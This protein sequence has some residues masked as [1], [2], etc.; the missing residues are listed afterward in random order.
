MH[1]PITVSQLAVSRKL[2]QDAIMESAT[3]T[4]V[5]RPILGSTTGMRLS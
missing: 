4:A 2:L 1:V 3:N 5:L